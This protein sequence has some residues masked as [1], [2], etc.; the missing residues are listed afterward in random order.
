MRGERRK[1]RDESTEGGTS[2]AALGLITFQ[3]LR[4]PSLSLSFLSPW[5]PVSL[6]SIEERR[7][8]HNGPNTIRFPRNITENIKEVPEEMMQLLMLL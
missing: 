3:P 5:H 6:A 4:P 1:Q 7:R 8:S 2:S